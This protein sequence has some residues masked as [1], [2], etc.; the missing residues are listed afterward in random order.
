MSSTSMDLR[1]IIRKLTSRMKLDE[2]EIHQ[3]IESILQ[4]RTS[5][6]SAASF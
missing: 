2:A 6:A 5:E 1:P 3:S 4:G